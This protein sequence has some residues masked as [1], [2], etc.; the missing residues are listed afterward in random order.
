MGA[1]DATFETILLVVGIFSLTMVRHVPD[2]FRSGM[3]SIRSFPH[4]LSVS[5][6]RRYILAPATELQN[7]DLIFQPDE[8]NLAAMRRK[9]GLTSVKSQQSVAPLDRRTRQQAVSPF[10]ALIV[11]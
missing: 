11:N 1:T 5:C 2:T 4:H 6:P 9:P 10:G 8:P 3:R 7:G